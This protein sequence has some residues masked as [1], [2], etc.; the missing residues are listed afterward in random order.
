[1]LETCGCHDSLKGRVTNV[2]EWVLRGIEEEAR[3]HC[4]PSLAMLRALVLAHELGAARARLATTASGFTGAV[5]D[6]IGCNVGQQDRSGLVCRFQAVCAIVQ[7]RMHPEQHTPCWVGEPL[8]SAAQKRFW[9][10][11]WQVVEMCVCVCVCV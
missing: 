4:I 9:R 6:L 11:I 7:E 8:D 1:M 3:H 5:A 10:S 2:I